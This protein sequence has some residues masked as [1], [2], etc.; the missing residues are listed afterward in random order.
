MRII[1]MSR[2]S[3][4]NK[5]VI[6]ELEKKIF[7]ILVVNNSSLKPYVE[8][9]E[10]EPENIYQQP[11]GSL[12]GFFEVKEFSEESAY[13]VNF[14]T[15]V[16]KKEYYINPKRPVTESLDSALH[17]VNIA[18]SELAKHGNIEWLGKINA[19]ICVLEKNNAHFSV[20]GDAKI[21][22]FRSKNLSEISEGLAS[23]IV[24]PHPL[25]TFVNV[26]SGRLENNDRLMITSADIFH[27]LSITEISKNFQRFE[28][29]KFVQFLK[30]ALSNQLEMI[31]SIVVE[32]I[33]PVPVPVVKTLARKKSLQAANAF[34]EQTFANSKS[35]TNTLA[36]QEALAAPI[37]INEND[38]E[39]TDEKTGHIYIQGEANDEPESANPQIGLYWDIVKEK[40]SNGSYA[41]KN[42]IRRRFSLYKKQLDRKKELRRIEKEKQA[43]FDA[44]EKKRLE[45]ERILQE[46]KVQQELTQLEVE[47]QRIRLKQEKEDQKIALMQEKTFQAE[48]A[49]KRKLEEEN[50]A[51]KSREQKLKKI[52]DVEDEEGQAELP[53]SALSFLEKLRLAQLEQKHNTVIDL[54]LKSKTPI[55]EIVP[56]MIEKTVIEDTTKEDSKIEKLKNI[57]KEYS[58]ELLLLSKNLFEKT[59]NKTREF[60][61]KKNNQ[62]N[63]DIEKQSHLSIAPHFRKISSLFSKF[64]NKQK[65]YTIGGLIMVFVVPLF[66]VHFLNQP[67]KPT[68]TDLQVTTPIVQ[69]N[70]LA[71][72]KNIQLDTKSQ[73]ALSNAGIISTLITNAGA[74]A[75][76]KNA[77]T[78][79]T[80][81]KEI[82]LPSDSGNAVSATY[83][84]DLSLVLIFTDQNKVISFSPTSLKFINNNITLPTNISEYLLGTYLT[85]L[86]ILDNKA[87]QIYRYPRAEGGF[88]EKT[89][90]YK[91]STSLANVSALTMDEN[92]YAVKDNNI[93]KLF[94]GKQLD[95]KLENSATPVNLDK[96]FTTIDDQYIYALD[97][98]NGRLVQYTKEGSIFAQY[99]NESLKSALGLAVDETNKLA[100][101]TTP[102]NLLS[103]PIQ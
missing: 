12:V 20:S 16:L 28:G 87:N 19:A 74:V 50:Q 24:E 100:Y 97:S 41:T 54:S 14:L 98:K 93:L 4:N 9:F 84:S 26:S 29:D 73:I 57:T 59:K 53:T 85:Y 99:Q 45:E 88:G 11:L 80:S 49:K 7:P 72:E 52:E 6:K 64:S 8:L 31:V 70:T 27:I 15:S 60:S 86:Y 3:L 48:I 66:I 30:T 21:F 25:K 101:I 63:T 90:W 75:I 40:I 39:Y 58:Q 37:L 78:I 17:K 55:E 94:K 46:I 89:N 22:L 103:L 1:L 47:S 33:E 18:L 10:Y 82:S 51:Q 92:I 43:E 5:D 83:M 62:A 42:E 69:A 32:M 81:K 34:S 61:A 68:I 35:K 36:E 65:L 67:K 91:D 96:I 38:P 95:F 23:D 13:I 77:V 44:K 102:T 2:T 56:V 71:N 79:L 76:S